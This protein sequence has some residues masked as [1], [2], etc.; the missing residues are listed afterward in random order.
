MASLGT[1]RL[2][3][4]DDHPIWRTGIRAD[5]GQGFHVVGEAGTAAEAVRLAGALNPDVVITD[6]RLPDGSGLDITRALRKNS[7]TIGIV[8]LTMYAGDDQLFG[9]LEAGAAG[10][11]AARSRL[12]RG[13]S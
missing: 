6:L 9:A 7:N 5:L 1:V 3:V 10:L 8:V 13:R 2:V 4:A 11:R 12:G